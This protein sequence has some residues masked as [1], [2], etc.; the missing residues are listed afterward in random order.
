MLPLFE[1]LAREAG[2]AILA[3]RREGFVLETK[4][5]ASPV[6]RADRVA[7]GIILAGLRAADPDLAI[8]AEEE[9]ALSAEPP[10][11]E[12]RFVLVDA[13]DGTRDFVA[14]GDD[15]TVNIALVEDGVPVAGVVHVPVT[16]A[17]YGGDGTGAWRDGVAIRTAP[18][19]PPRIVASRSHR[20]AETDAWIADVQR[21]HGPCEIVHVGS[22]LKFCL[23]AEGS[24]DLY[25][26]FGRTME[27]DVAA[28]DAIL[29]AAG[30]TTWHTDGR[31][32]V[33]GNVAPRD[34]AFS[35]PDFIAAAG[36]DFPG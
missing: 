26:R 27:W 23:L 14:G 34:A 16:G 32:F 7:E 24:A 4:G 21:R 19:V 3:V 25:P 13:L 17:T 1:R 8:V 9:V 31:P 18:Q 11:P 10:V 2:A 29:R 28:G 6:T 36:R 5:D 33:Y 15:F 22:S 20:T 35:N 12:R 30:G